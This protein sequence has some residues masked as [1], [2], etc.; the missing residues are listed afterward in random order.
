MYSSEACKTSNVVRL[1]EVEQSKD[2]TSG[3]LID[4]IEDF[5]AKMG[6]CK[7]DWIVE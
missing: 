7:E 2:L 1:G 4:R 3:W 5:K 6:D